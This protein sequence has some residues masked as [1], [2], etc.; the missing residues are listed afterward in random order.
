ML[1]GRE[2]FEAT[3]VLQ[4]LARHL[5]VVPDAPSLHSPFRLPPALEEIVLAC[6]AK[7]P[8][9][10]PAGAWELAERLAQVEVGSPWTREDARPWWN[11][12]LDSEAA[13]TFAD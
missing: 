8:A 13:V 10:R 6:L 12:L 9:D 7:R 5:Q 11:T 3:G 2:V 4:M 1:T